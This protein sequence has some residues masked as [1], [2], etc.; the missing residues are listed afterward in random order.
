MIE[1][2]ENISDSRKMKNNN[3]MK[4]DPIV[5]ISEET[6]VDEQFSSTIDFILPKGYNLHSTKRQY[7]IEKVLG[8]GT[9]GITYLANCNGKPVAI[10]EYFMG[11]FCGRDSS[12][13]EVTGSC[14]GNQIEYY[15]KKFLTEARNLQKLSHPS[16]IKIYE[17]FEANNTYYYSMEYIDGETLDDYILKNKR[18]DETEAI[19]YLWEISKAVKYIHDNKMLHLDLKPKNIMRKAD[20]GSLV[21]IDFGLSKQFTDDGLA[22]SSSNVG[23]G[24]PGYAPTEQIAHNGKVFAPWLDVYALGGILYK[25]LTGKT[26]PH[27]SEVLNIGLPI[28]ELKNIK[29]SS[30]TINL[31]KDMM[32]PMWRKRIQTVDKVIDLLPLSPEQKLQQIKEQGVLDQETIDTLSELPEYGGEGTKDVHKNIL[33]PM[34]LIAISS[35]FTA[36]GVIELLDFLFFDGTPN[37]INSWAFWIFVVLLCDGV[38]IYLL[39]TSTR[40][41]IYRIEAIAIFV[42]MLILCLPNL[43]WDKLELFQSSF[44]HRVTGV[45]EIVYSVGDVKFTMIPVKKGSFMMGGDGFELDGDQIHEVILTKDFLLGET[46]VTQSL[47]KSVMGEYSI[48]TD[49]IDPSLPANNISYD[50]ALLFIEKLNEITGMHFRLPTEAEWEYAARGGNK[51]KNYK[52]SG[53]DNVGDVAWYEDNSY[54][55]VHKVATKKPNELGFYDMTGNVEEWCQDQYVTFDNQDQVVDPLN[56]NPEGHQVARGGSYDDPSHSITANFHSINDYRY[57]PSGSGLRLAL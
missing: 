49:E 38:S 18:L 37:I 57:T 21:V 17:V 20:D 53:S 3:K 55:K 45:G 8:K 51:S 47:W 29:I 6:F 12:S 23:L 50:D 48:E 33:K 31:L 34:F 28:E 13:M 56:L 26:P 2:R 19:G 10:K 25:M 1:Q 22:E 40:R 39:M 11:Q 4:E 43:K 7:V 16:V 30:K 24:T 52:Y 54:K 46:E 9:F 27:A 36:M 15:G 5:E 41:M 32:Q 35:I 14:P 44:D 42:F